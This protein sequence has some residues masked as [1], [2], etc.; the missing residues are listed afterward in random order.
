M[1]SIDFSR[2]A[3]LAVA[4]MGALALGGCFSTDGPSAVVSPDVTN[5]PVGE[6]LNVTPGSREDF[7]V[8]V[9]RRIFF[10]AGSAELDPDAKVTL[11]KQAAWLAKHPGWFV[12][13][14]GFAD[15]PGS[16]QSNMELGMRRAKAAHD[17]LA[18]RGIPGDRMKFKSFGNATERQVKDCDD[19]S[20]TAQNRRVVVVIQNGRG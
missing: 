6:G 1:I 19:R 2:G 20:C 13:V 17:Y 12:K 15:D 9:G 14:E 4:L 7:I 10:A 8:N 5:A 3:R 18:S 16:A 11:D